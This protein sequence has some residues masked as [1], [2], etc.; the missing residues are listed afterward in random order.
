MR[1][2]F[3]KRVFYVGYSTP[4][5]LQRTIFFYI[6][7]NFVLRGVQEQQDLVP[8]QFN[9]VP[10]DRSVYNTAVY[11]EY[12]ELVSKNNQHRFK[13]I[14][15]QNKVIRAYALPGNQKCIVKMLDKYVSFTS[16]Y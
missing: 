8:S 14:N 12:T 2:H 11:Y 15:A 9:H 16:T 1:I 5:I 6:G 13:D 10:Q 7:L 3:G 4:K